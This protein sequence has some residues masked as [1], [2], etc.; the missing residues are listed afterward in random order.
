[1]RMIMAKNAQSPIPRRALRTK[2]EAR[3]DLERD[4]R[5]R[6]DIGGEYRLADQAVLSDQQAAY[7]AA[8]GRPRLRLKPRQQRP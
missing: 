6:R 7:F 3:L 1:M 8:L 5:I 4:S 2:V